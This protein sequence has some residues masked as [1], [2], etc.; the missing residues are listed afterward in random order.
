VWGYPEPI[1]PWLEGFVAFYGDAM[2][3][4]Y[5]EDEQ[6]FGH[7]RDPYSRIDVLKSS[8]RVKVS[9]DGTVLA[10]S[11]RPIMLFE[12]GLPAR[13]YLPREDVRL[14]LLE[15]SETRSQCPYKGQARYWSYGSADIAWTYEDPLHDA[16]GVRDLICFLDE[17]ADIEV[18]GRPQER[19]HSRWS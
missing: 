15:P 16:G 3:G 11:D 8:R 14:D 2:D 7:P 4:W 6:V 10:E 12:T 13:Y 17:R 5:E 1:A 18:D 9:V 19:P